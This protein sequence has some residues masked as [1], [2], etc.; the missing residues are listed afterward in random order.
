MLLY[1][2]GLPAYRQEWA[3]EVEDGYAGF[4]LS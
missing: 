1:P 4:R 2:G 3:A